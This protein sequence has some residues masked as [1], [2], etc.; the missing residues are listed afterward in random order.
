MAARCSRRDRRRF[1]TGKMLVENVVWLVALL[2]PW[3]AL[4]VNM[5]VFGGRRGLLTAFLSAVGMY[6]A[7]LLCVHLIDAR[8]ERELYVFDLNG[9]GAFA[10]DEINPAQERAM[11]NLVNDTARAM[12]PITGAV[13]SILYVGL[14]AISLWIVRRGIAYASRRRSAGKSGASSAG[15]P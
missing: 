15:P 3:V 6:V 14:V 10:Q 1:G 2:I 7:L 4:I 12:A 11:K 9:D 13:L 8:L 5:R